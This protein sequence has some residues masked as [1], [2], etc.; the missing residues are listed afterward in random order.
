MRPSSIRSFRRLFTQF[1][2]TRIFAQRIPVR[3]DSENSRR[4]SVGHFQQ[5][6]K[7]GDGGIDIADLSF[8]L[9]EYDFRLRLF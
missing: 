1:L 7:G 5:V 3:I 6:R 2:E 8:D 4:K 9:R